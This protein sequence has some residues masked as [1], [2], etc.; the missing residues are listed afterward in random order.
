MGASRRR[1]GRAASGCSSWTRCTA[2]RS[3]SS[4]ARGPAGG[5]LRRAGHDAADLALAVLVADCVPVLLADPDAGVRGGVHAGR[6]GML[7][8]IV[9]RTLAVMRELGRDDRLGRRGSLGVRPLLPGAAGDARGRGAESGRCPRPCPGPGR[10][11]ST[12]RPGWSTSSGRTACDVR[13]VPGCTGSPT[14]CS[15]TVATGGPAGSRA[16]S[17]CC[18]SGGSMSDVDTDGGRSSSRRPGPRRRA[19]TPRA[20]ERDATR[21]DVTARRGHQVLPGGR[22]R[23]ARRARRARRGG[24]PRPGGLGQGR[25]GPGAGPSTR[26]ARGTSSGSCSATRRDPWRGTPTSSTPSTGE[27]VGHALTA[28]ADAAGRQLHASCRSTSTPAGAGRGR[29]R[30][31]RGA[32]VWP[33]PSR[34]PR[35]RPAGADG[36]GAARRPTPCGRSRGCSEGA[37]A[38]R[39]PPG[40]DAGCLPA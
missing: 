27:L 6:A 10:R 3:T 7:A 37:P 15:P 16:S 17:G 4:R 23:T 13:W 30:A 26:P 20:S 25:R 22:R 1:S 18:P 21:Q 35:P 29:G 32:R 39:R 36:G 14:T 11:P 9:G 31:R 2:T 12:S 40:G 38:P 28:G 19:R 5:L 24:E 34:G 33:T 8:G